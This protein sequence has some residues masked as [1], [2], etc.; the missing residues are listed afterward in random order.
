MPGVL[1][2]QSPASNKRKRSG[3]AAN[4]VCATATRKQKRKLP[5]A[6]PRV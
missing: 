1:P 6:Y 3:A 5:K 2:L 4:A